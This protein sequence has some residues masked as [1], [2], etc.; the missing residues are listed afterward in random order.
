MAGSGHLPKLTYLSR[1]QQE[2]IHAASLEI[3]ERVGAL[4]DDEQSAALL[5]KAGIRRDD[6]GAFHIPA[7]R[8]QWALS[9]APK[10]IVLH[11]RNGQAVMPLEP[12]RI[13]FGLGR[14]GQAKPLFNK[15]IQLDP[16]KRESARKYLDQ[17]R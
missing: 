8:V 12:G 16:K 11:D 7:K 2:E 14:Q 13:Y 10:R 15:A 4:I 1:K 9:L 6:R 5:R 17:M 3:L